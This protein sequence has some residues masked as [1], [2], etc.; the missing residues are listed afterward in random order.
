MKNLDQQCQARF[1]TINKTM[2]K[3][4]TT[5]TF[6][7][8]SI[9]STATAFEAKLVQVTAIERQ[10]N[11]KLQ[12]Q[13]SETWVDGINSN[14]MITTVRD[15]SCRAKTGTIINV[16]GAIGINT[17]NQPLNKT[18]T[19]LEDDAYGKAIAPYCQN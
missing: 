2:L 3:L 18:V 4:A 11:Q 13:F 9:A 8:L 6:C 5:L 17:F 10:P 7:L 14:F 16:Q 1:K 12:V 15:F 19:F